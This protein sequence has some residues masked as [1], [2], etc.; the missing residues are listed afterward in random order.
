MTS[1]I[2]V[3]LKQVRFFAF[4]GLYEEEKREGND[5]EV[6]LAVSF[7][8]Q[9]DVI[10]SIRETIN[11]AVLYEI[12]NAEMQEPRDLLETLTMTM[13]AKIKTAYPEVKKITISITKLNPP[14]PGI[15]GSTAVTY[16][17]EW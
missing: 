8:P 17:K 5:F 11:Y 7:F 10:N 3:E 15:K 6:S 16:S 9:T 1:L 4:H 14:I 12:V 13:A 2:T